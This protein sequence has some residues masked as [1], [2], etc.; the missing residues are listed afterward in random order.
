MN[1]IVRERYPVEKLPNDLRL[2]SGT[3]RVTVELV[4][5]PTSDQP[6][7]T[8]LLDEMKKYRRRGED[9]VARV[10]SLRS[11]WDERAEMIDRIRS[12]GD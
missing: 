11:E 6:A 4:V 8:T 12:G 9:P 7:L 10:R 5:P 1:R 3:V 2:G